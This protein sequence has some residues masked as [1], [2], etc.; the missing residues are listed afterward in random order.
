MKVFES[1]LFERL[2][3]QDKSLAQ[4][5]RNFFA[6]FIK[7][8]KNALADIS[9]RNA[10]YKALKDDITAKE[11]ILEMFDE[12]LDYSNEESNGNEDIKFS[13]NDDFDE[14]YDFSNNINIVANMDPV[15]DLTGNE[16]KKNSDGIVVQVSKFFNTLGNKVTTKYGDVILDNKGVKSS[17]AHGLGRIK[18]T[19]Y[20]AVPSV[21]KHGEV[22]NYSKN[23]NG[24]KKDRV[25]FATLIKIDVENYFV[26][27]V[28]EINK[29]NNSF[30]LHEVA[31]QN[32]KE[33]N[34][35]F[36][37]GSRKKS[38]PS[39]A[40]SSIYSL[41]EELQNV[42]SNSMQDESRFSLNTYI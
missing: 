7:K 31:L 10:E 1:A 5:V 30:Y 2:V 18:A 25:V 26:A 20:K 17:L 42:N 32:K 4:K 8:I 13:L 35:P 38:S 6:D 15:I 3:K 24:G 9:S 16:F 39:G 28:V 37:T 14:T 29:I 21:L 11:K 33:D 12:A 40:T 23:Y 22:I 36:K 34:A 41:L 27:V 19:A